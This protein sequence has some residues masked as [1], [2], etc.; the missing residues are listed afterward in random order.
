MIVRFIKHCTDQHTHTG[1]NLRELYIRRNNVSDMSEVLHLVEL[2]NLQIL[3]MSENPIASI[4]G[5][6]DYI[7]KALPQLCKL[8]S[9]GW[10][11]AA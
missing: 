7:V 10:L 6:R 1:S 11:M 2:K 9:Q 3:W 5:Y 4:P 8:D